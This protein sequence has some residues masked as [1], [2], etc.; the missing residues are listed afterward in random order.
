MMIE[1]YMTSMSIIMIRQA[2]HK[3]SNSQFYAEFNPYTF[4]SWE[5]RLPERWGNW[6]ESQIA[7]Y[8]S[9]ETGK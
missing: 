1:G 8:E 7:W 2:H 6:Q 3:Q 9:W 5:L 4:E